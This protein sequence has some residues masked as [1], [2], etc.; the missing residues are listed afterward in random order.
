MVEK[1]S[2]RNNMKT[3]INGVL[4]G[5]KISVKIISRIGNIKE[6]ITEL[7]KL[8]NELKDQDCSN[9]ELWQNIEFDI[10]NKYNR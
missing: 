10:L 6:S 4:Y 2:L 7:C 9:I 1:M 8:Q 3:Y 5:I